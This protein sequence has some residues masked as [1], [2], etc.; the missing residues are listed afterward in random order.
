MNEKKELFADFCA[1]NSLIIGDSVF[2]HKATWR[3]PDH[4][5]ENQIDLSKKIVIQKRWKVV[6][7]VTCCSFVNLSCNKIH[8]Y[9]YLLGPSRV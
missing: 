8:S 6:A 4:V 5:T 3:S 7:E 1:Q 9:S 2:E